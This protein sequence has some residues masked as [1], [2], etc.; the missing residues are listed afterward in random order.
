MTLRPGR[1]LL[2]SERKQLRQLVSGNGMVVLVDDP[3]ASG[4]SVEAAAAALMRSGV[5]Q[6]SIV[7]LLAVF[8][9]AKTLPPRLRCFKSIVL[10]WADWAVQQELN[11]TAVQSTLSRLLGP[12]TRVSSV[13][14]SGQPDAGGQRRHVGGLFRARLKAD[15]QA[16]RDVQVYVRGVG[17]GYLGRQ[18]LAVANRLGGDV[19]AVYGVANGLIYREWLSEPWQPLQADANDFGAGLAAYVVDRARRLPASQD[20]SV[21]RS[22]QFPAWEVASMVLSR[23]FGRF[24]MAARLPLTNPLARRLLHVRRPSVVDGHTSLDRWWTDDGVSPRRLRK[25]GFEDGVFHS[26]LELTSYDPVTDIAGVEPGARQ[27]ELSIDIR[28]NYERL[29][30]EPISEE[31]WL[32]HQLVHLWNQQRAP[33]AVDAGRRASSRAL[34]RYLAAQLLT[35]MTPPLQG[36]LCALD[37]DG[38]LETD[39]FG[40]SATT[41]A[42]AIAL[43]GLLRH[44]YRVVLATG[45]SLD[46]VRERCEIFPLAGGVAEYGAAAYNHASG[47]SWSLLTGAELQDLEALRTFLQRFPDV[48]VDPDFAYSVRAYGLD[49]RGRRRALASRTVESALRESAVRGEIIA[50]T[51]DSQTDFVFKRIDKGQGLLELASD[52]GKVTVGPSGEP[53]ALSVGDSPTDLPMLRLARLARAPR[54]AHAELARA[55]VPLTRQPYQAGLAEAV[56]DLLGHAPGTCPTCRLEHPLAPETRLLL[57][58]LAIRESNAWAALAR[59]IAAVVRVWLTCSLSL[60]E[61]GGVRGAH[62]DDVAGNSLACER[63]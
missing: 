35:R 16:P 42:G 44:G 27:P 22:G 20:W 53:L 25:T 17:V 32:L 47:R 60:W 40:C 15:S 41:P 31:R 7:L 51:G 49:E 9:S 6:Q 26:G 43:R 30:G 13:E 54:N 61:R 18:A 57:P 24:A 5:P 28:R 3:P 34:Q 62:D 50:L 19:P 14:G 38:V 8:G 52:L 12:A 21:R 11:P 1:S 45:R 36:Q 23:E 33:A 56:T 63:H 2:D 4:E 39:V 59:T 37:V 46:E 58:L 55:G 29:T 10:P 48:H